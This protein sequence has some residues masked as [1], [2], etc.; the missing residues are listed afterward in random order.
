MTGLTAAFIAAGAKALSKYLPT[1][2]ALAVSLAAASPA[3]ARVQFVNGLDLRAVAST[4]L[5]QAVATTDPVEALNSG[6]QCSAQRISIGRALF[7][8]GNPRYTRIFNDQGE[9][10]VAN[11]LA[12]Y[13]TFRTNVY[14]RSTAAVTQRQGIMAQVLM[15][16]SGDFAQT[17]GLNFNYQFLAGFKQIESTMG[18]HNFRPSNRSASLDAR[19]GNALGPSQIQLAFFHDHWTESWAALRALTADN[20]MMREHPLYARL[21]DKADPTTGELAYNRL[22]NREINELRLD[23]YFASV[24]SVAGIMMRNNM[25]PT[26]L[27]RL[28]DLAMPDSVATTLAADSRLSGLIPVNYSP[29]ARIQTQTDQGPCGH[30]TEEARG[31]MGAIQERIG[32]L[33]FWGRAY[34]GHQLG[35]GGLRMVEASENGAARYRARYPQ[36][37]RANG[38]F[39]RGVRSSSDLLG[40]FASRFDDAVEAAAP[41]VDRARPSFMAAAIRRENL[42]IA[43]VIAGEY[44]VLNHSEALEGN[45]LHIPVQIASLPPIQDNHEGSQPR[46]IRAANRYGHGSQVPPSTGL[47]AAVYTP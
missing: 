42:Q 31:L 40:R 35:N 13:Q 4:Q 11:R 5:Q 9:R 19:I 17:Y 28:N 34:A 24:M 26:T 10:P 1:G 29:A 45:Y 44:G 32:T 38:P 22:T 7:A 15:D 30:L 6:D 12:D 25:N 41:I 14:D 46:I 37:A 39:W 3:E 33:D 43:S 47:V 18:A 16:V 8:D 23:P 20:N 21:M 36:N 27:H 2:A